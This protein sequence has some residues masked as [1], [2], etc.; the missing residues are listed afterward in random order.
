VSSR[1][2]VGGAAKYLWRKRCSVGAD[3]QT[4]LKGVSV[5]VFQPVVSFSCAA[6]VTVPA[7]L[8]F[9]TKAATRKAMGPVTMC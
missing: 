8:F 2:K 3:N 5:D 9:W 6:G 4:S 1:L 7:C